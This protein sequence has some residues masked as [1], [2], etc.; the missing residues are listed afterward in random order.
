V[1]KEELVL[2]YGHRPD[3]LRQLSRR[4]EPRVNVNGIE[5]TKRTP[6]Q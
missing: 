4:R 3:A 2:R 6:T 5:P 1:F